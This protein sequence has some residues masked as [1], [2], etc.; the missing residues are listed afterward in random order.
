MS[1]GRRM[2]AQGESTTETQAALRAER[3][4]GWLRVPLIVAALLAI[5]TIIVQESE[6]GGIW[7][8]LAT[9]LDWCIW[10]MFAANLLIMLSIVP[11]RRRWLI[12]N[13]LDVL[14]VVFTPPFLPATM[15]LAR[16]LPVVR[17]VWLVVVANRLRNVFSLQG[18]RYAVLIVF[19]IVVGGGVVFVAV[20]PGQHLS[21]WEGLWW[22]AETV[23][24]VAYGDI[25][26]T[27]T[28]GCIV[29]AVVMTAG[30]G[31]V[32]MLTG[33]LAQ[34]F[35]YGAGQDTTPQP[36]SDDADIARKI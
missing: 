32:A 5:P 9:V 16:V 19:T 8:V 29:A 11:D 4:A 31:F 6:L 24:T 21:T 28:L 14:I 23:T 35:L 2:Q 1:R 25:Y 17:L 18:L 26:P 22:A 20:E 10:A 30:I 36:K 34:R 33:A 3:V 27:T 15:K 7:E 12:E 13:P